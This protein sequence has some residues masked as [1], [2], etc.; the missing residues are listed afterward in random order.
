MPVL[1]LGAEGDAFFRPA[2]VRETAEA[3]GVE[4]HIF[5]D[6]AHAMM[7]EPRWRLVADTILEWLRREVR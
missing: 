1:V 5:P 2:A 6:M 3:F 4:A 7:L